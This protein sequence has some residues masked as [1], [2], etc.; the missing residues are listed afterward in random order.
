MLSIALGGLLSVSEIL[1]FVK[2]V[3]TNGIIHFVVSSLLKDNDGQ[4]DAKDMEHQPLLNEQTRISRPSHTVRDDST[5]TSEIKN[6]SD[7]SLQMEGIDENC[8]VSGSTSLFVEDQDQINILI[9]KVNEINTELLNDAL[10]VN[11][12]QLSVYSSKQLKVLTEMQKS[13]S[14]STNDILVKLKEIKEEKTQSFASKNVEDIVEM[15]LQHLQDLQRSQMQWTQNYGDN[16][17]KNDIKFENIINQINTLNDTIKD[18][19]KDTIK[20]TIKDTLKESRVNNSN[21]ENS[22]DE[23]SNDENS[24]DENSNDN[25]LKTNNMILNMNESFNGIVKQQLENQ[26]E[27]INENFTKQSSLIDGLTLQFNNL[28]AKMDE[29]TDKLGDVND[30]IDKKKRKNNFLGGGKDL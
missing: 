14:D 4:G 30:K 3:K 23:N 16:T 18:T 12:Q 21:D 13:F 28:V 17:L 7:D 20:D 5:S 8:K 2:N 22:N 9:D 26:F 10:D 15:I 6:N 19:L 29:I 1:P 25:S 27:L 11:M 24:N